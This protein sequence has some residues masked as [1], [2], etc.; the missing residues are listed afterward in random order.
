MTDQLGA[1]FTK[2][3]R[4]HGTQRVIL[5]VERLIRPAGHLLPAS[6]EKEGSRNVTNPLSPCGEGQGEG[7][8][9]TEIAPFPDRA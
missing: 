6:G 1:A 7:K 8:V 2:F 3:V 4:A 9:A 5:V